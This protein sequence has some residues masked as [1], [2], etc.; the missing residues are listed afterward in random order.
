MV[1]FNEKDITMLYLYET[2]L[3]CGQFFVKF[4]KRRDFL[5]VFTYLYDISMLKYNYK[6]KVRC[7]M[8]KVYNNQLELASKLAD[9]FWKFLPILEKLNLRLFLLLFLV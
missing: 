4:K 8:N 7:R 5:F 6:N 3:M 1:F 9:F 2:M